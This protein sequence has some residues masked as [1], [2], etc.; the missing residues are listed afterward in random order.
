MM[1]LDYANDSSLRDYLSYNYLDW[2]DKYRIAYGF[3]NIHYSEMK[4]ICSL[5]Y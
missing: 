4:G 3:E 5:V 1:V 2:Y